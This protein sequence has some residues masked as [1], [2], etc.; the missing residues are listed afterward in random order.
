MSLCERAPFIIL[1]KCFIDSRHEANVIAILSRL[2]FLV[3]CSMSISVYR[4]TE[5]ILSLWRRLLVKE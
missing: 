4:L 5:A 1:E 3:Q 2:I